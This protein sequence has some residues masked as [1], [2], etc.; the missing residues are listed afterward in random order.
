MAT[1]DKKY[2]EIDYTATVQDDDL[3]AL[4]RGTGT[5]GSLATSASV[6]KNYIN[7]PVFDSNKPITRNVDGFY[8]INIGASTIQDFLEGAFFPAVTPVNQDIM[9]DFT[10][11]LKNYYYDGVNVLFNNP[12]G[13]GGTCYAHQIMLMFF[14]TSNTLMYIVI[15]PPGHYQFLVKN[16]M[17]NWKMAMA[18]G[19]VKQNVTAK[20]VKINN[21]AV[22]NSKLD[23]GAV[24]NNFNGLY[25]YRWLYPPT[26]VGLTTNLIVEAGDINDS[27]VPL[28]L[29][30]EM[31]LVPWYWVHNL[32]FFSHL[33]FV[34]N[35]NYDTVTNQYVTWAPEYW[36]QEFRWIPDNWHALAFIINSSDYPVLYDA[37]FRRTSGDVLALQ[38]AERDQ[39]SGVQ[40]GDI[41]VMKQSVG[42]PAGRIKV[43]DAR[44]YSTDAIVIEVFSNYEMAFNVSLP[45]DTHYFKDTS[46]ANGQMY[47][48]MRSYDMTFGTANQ[49]KKFAVHNGVT[50][51]N[52]GSGLIF[53]QTVNNG[54]QR[55]V[56]IQDNP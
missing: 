15:L 29:K 50:H 56:T 22:V 21:T 34:C 38:Y 23:L 25:D 5:D 20:Y 1:G 49:F 4:G 51:T 36:T 2:F 33:I 30:N 52:S 6:F 53:F 47:F 8:G 31:P 3:I 42:N 48:F 46:P 19:A 16:V 27:G 18:I 9:F 44:Q 7:S 37:Y 55:V 11:T 13:T 26:I 28:I 24:V 17:S 54:G 35:Q 14:D 10:N 41:I 43:I 45:G 40:T 12:N 39:I 32:N